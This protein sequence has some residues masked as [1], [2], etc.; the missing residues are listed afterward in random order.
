MTEIVPLDYCV[1]T[2]NLKKTIESGF[3]V[4]GERLAN[5]K[6]KE[7]WTEQWSS[8]SEFLGEMNINDS[9]ASKMITVYRT[10]IQDYKIDETLLIETGWDKLYLAKELVAKA[11]TQQE[12][13]DIV[14]QISLLKREDAKE[15]IR[16]HHNP[17]CVHEWKE[18]HLRCCSKCNKK[19]Q[20]C[21]ESHS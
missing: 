1:T 7:M 6:D 2:I 4:L 12:V 17:D 11:T 14:T 9:T 5:I 15:L 18:I 8:F 19:E 13:I 10:Y 20:I 21:G 3:I 16:E